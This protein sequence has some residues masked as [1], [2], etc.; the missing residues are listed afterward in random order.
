MYM[1][2]VFVFV[3]CVIHK[4]EKFN[5]TISLVLAHQPVSPFL[6]SGNFLHNNF[7]ITE[8]FTP[9][10]LRFLTPFSFSKQP[11]AT[12]SAQPEIINASI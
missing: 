8:G 7:F 3:G 6:L 2:F 4:T 12:A 11:L 1:V 10:I 5:T 9:A